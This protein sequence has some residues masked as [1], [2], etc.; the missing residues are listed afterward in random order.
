M[1]VG[2][3]RWVGPRGRRDSRTCAHDFLTHRDRSRRYRQLD[4]GA[5]RVEREV[6]LSTNLATGEVKETSGS[7]TPGSASVGSISA[8]HR[9][10]SAVGLRIFVVFL[11]DVC[12]TTQQHLGKMEVQTSDGRGLSTDC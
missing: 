6:D 4:S 7:K 9:R 2:H 8:P 10:A 3:A 1:V 12:R 5:V 11:R